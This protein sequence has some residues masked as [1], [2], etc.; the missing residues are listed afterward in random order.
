MLLLIFLIGCYLFCLLA[1]PVREPIAASKLGYTVHCLGNNLEGPAVDLAISLV[2]QAAA[3]GVGRCV[4][5]RRIRLKQRY[6]Y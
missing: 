1:P 3:L 2:S 6:K 4:I 5:G